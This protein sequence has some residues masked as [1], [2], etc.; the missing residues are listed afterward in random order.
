MGA[1]A[2]II[3]RI[4]RFR[5]R[6]GV[7]D[8]GAVRCAGGAREMVAQQRRGARTVAALGL[9]Q[10]MAVGEVGDHP[11]VHVDAALG[12]GKGVDVLGV[13]RRTLRRPLNSG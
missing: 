11:G 9:L 1:C 7:L 12:Q 10:R 5:E 3:H 8:I 2:A 4:S 6:E 13:Q